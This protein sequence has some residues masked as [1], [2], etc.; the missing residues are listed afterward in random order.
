MGKTA[1][2]LSSAAAH[3]AASIPAR[4]GFTS[5][6][7]RGFM[8]NE[9]EAMFG[10]A[11]KINEAI[12][13][14]EKTIALA[15][16]G[17][18]MVSSSLPTQDA[19]VLASQL[20][21]DLVTAQREVIELSELFPQSRYF[22]AG[23]LGRLAKTTGDCRDYLTGLRAA[24]DPNMAQDKRKIADDLGTLHRRL[25]KDIGKF[26]KDVQQVAKSQKQKIT[27]DMQVSR[28]LTSSGA[29]TKEHGG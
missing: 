1:R 9:P 5:T 13:G 8:K 24:W 29:L 19:N 28:F 6:A 15:K 17:F 11:N 22:C 7:A 18:A 12:D 3:T 16:S 14:L 21:A 20:E 25:K 27:S 4:R 2:V 23:S 26:R 10:Y